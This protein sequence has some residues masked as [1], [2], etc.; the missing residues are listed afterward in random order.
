[1]YVVVVGHSDD[2]LFIWETGTQII[3]RCSFTIGI[4]TKI[5]GNFQRQTLIVL[6]T[7]NTV[8]NK[9]GRRDLYLWT[10]YCRIHLHICQNT[11]VIITN[12]SLVRLSAAIRVIPQNYRFQSKIE[13][14]LSRFTIRINTPKR[15]RGAPT[16][17]SSTKCAF[18]Q[19]LKLPVNRQSPEH[20]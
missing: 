4:T 7:P 17:M 12:L 9:T 13:F 16:H 8:D 11:L 19:N 18:K 14:V 1:M 2:I 20:P 3:K 6:S 10:D 15:E 5:Y